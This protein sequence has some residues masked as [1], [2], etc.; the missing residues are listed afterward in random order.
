MSRY[1][2]PKTD[3]VFKKIFGE[4][5][6]LLKSFLNA[7]LPLPEN[8]LIDTLEY[9]PSEQVP[10]IPSFKYTVVDVRCTDQ[11]GQVFIVEMQI[12]WT[13]SFK[14]RMLFNA[15][16]AYVTQLEKGEDY[17]LLKPVYG[18]GLINTQFDPDENDWYHHYK[19]VNVAKPHLAE[20]KDL[21]LVFIELP[22]F[23]AKNF[24]QK[25][26]QVLWL[27]FLSELSEKTKEVSAEWL[28]VPE[29]KQAITLAEEAAYSPAEL[30]S[31]DKYWDAISI[32]KSLVSS[33]GRRGHEAGWEQGRIEG[34]VEGRVEGRLEGRK[35]GREEGIIEG[36]EEGSLKTRYAFAHKLM[37]KG[38]PLEEIAA[39]T[40]LP[41]T[42][43]NS[44]LLQEQE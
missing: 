36:R 44:L 43:I 25:K 3:I 40:E 33:A 38:F 5:P 37:A 23:K 15:S 19:I 24:P 13:A 27:R 34:R 17:D 4:H 31:Y 16:K 7:V 11:Q 42:V 1:L 12:Q 29:I 9:L 10:L 14:Q 28:A 18:L 6:H 22:K 30:A 32:E 8:G 26:L 2:D 35:E 21:Q 41:L 20:I 39:L